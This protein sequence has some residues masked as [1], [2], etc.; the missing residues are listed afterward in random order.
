MLCTFAIA[1]KSC[2]VAYLIIIELFETAQQKLFVKHAV[3]ILN[4]L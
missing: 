3:L 2:I 1:G 4:I